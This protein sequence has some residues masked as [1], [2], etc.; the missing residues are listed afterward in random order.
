LISFETAIPGEDALMSTVS[1]RQFR[2]PPDEQD[3]FRYGRGYVHASATDGTE[4]F[5][6]V[7][8][9]LEEVLF[10]KTRISLHI[11]GLPNDICRSVITRNL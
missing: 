8:L 5:T 6:Q 3:P 11:E 2:E 9:T 1:R 7:P 10:S 4:T